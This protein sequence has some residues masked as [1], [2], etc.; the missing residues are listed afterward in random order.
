METE[1]MRKSQ[2]QLA[3]NSGEVEQRLIIEEL[4][5]GGSNNTIG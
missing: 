5:Q 3:S 2:K 1:D 4:K